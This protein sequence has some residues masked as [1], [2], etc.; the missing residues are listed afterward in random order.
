[1]RLEQEVQRVLT[2]VRVKEFTKAYLASDP[3][4]KHLDAIKGDA[5]KIFEF[6]ISSRNAI[7]MASF[8]ENGAAA[9]HGSTI[10][11]ARIH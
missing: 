2:K 6:S 9:G 11:S 3:L 8:R 1:M 4:K 5:E 10:D 7:F